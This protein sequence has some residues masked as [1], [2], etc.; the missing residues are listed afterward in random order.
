MADGLVGIWASQTHYRVTEPSTGRSEVVSIMMTDEEASDP[1]FLK[2]IEHYAR[3]RVL[4]GWKKTEIRH[5][6]E[7]RRPL[8]MQERIDIG[9]A[10]KEIKGSHNYWRAALHGRYW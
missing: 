8:I 5:Q 10:L 3:D 7:N 4:A 9:Q 2:E 1:G 6:Q